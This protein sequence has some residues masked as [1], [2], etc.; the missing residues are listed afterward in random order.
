MTNPVDV[1]SCPSWLQ[2]ATTRVE[3]LLCNPKLRY[4]GEPVIQVRCGPA[5]LIQH[6]E[7]GQYILSY[8]YEDGYREYARVSSTTEVAK[9]LYKVSM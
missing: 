9:E 8:D 2:R 1:F 6:N 3:H 5:I 7:D 4:R